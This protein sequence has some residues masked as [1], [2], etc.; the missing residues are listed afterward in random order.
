M[1]RIQR[2]RFETEAAYKQV[3]NM[4]NIVLKYSCA[5]FIKKI[6]HLALADTIKTFSA[7]KDVLVII[8]SLIIF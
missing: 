7:Y 2:E 4:R 8:S 5:I 3:S 1:T 6:K